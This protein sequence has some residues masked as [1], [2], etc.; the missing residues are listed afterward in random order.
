MPLA[1]QNHFGGG[2]GSYMVC[3]S[4][5]GSCMPAGGTANQAGRQAE[6]KCKRKCASGQYPKLLN[7]LD[8]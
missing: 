5:P 2:Q 4:V 7:F 8:S 6:S 1:R 3:C